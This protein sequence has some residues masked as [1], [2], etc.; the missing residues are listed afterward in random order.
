MRVSVCVFQCRLSE[1][2]CIQ[3]ERLKPL[4]HWQWLAL[5]AVLAAETLP[6]DNSSCLAEVYVCALGYINPP[7]TLHYKSQSSTGLSTPPLLLS[8]SLTLTQSS[9]SAGGSWDQAPGQAELTVSSSQLHIKKEGGR[10]KR[11]EMERK[12]GGGGE[13]RR[14]KRE[15]GDAHI[16]GPTK[17]QYVQLFIKIEQIE[18]VHYFPGQK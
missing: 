3:R 12:E 13:R 4:S 8:S 18:I 9:H 14:G 16:H 11:R 10:R 5:S 2:V 7:L 15:K 17:E 6:P 1:S